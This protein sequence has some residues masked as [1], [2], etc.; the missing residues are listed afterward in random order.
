M[1][2]A[3]ALD[4]PDVLV[5]SWLV[6][7]FINAQR[8]LPG[9][10]RSEKKT[11]K[12]GA[13]ALAQLTHATK[14]AREH[15]LPLLLSL[16]LQCSADLLVSS[17]AGR[18]DVGEALANEASRVAGDQWRLEMAKQWLI[19][20]ALLLPKDTNTAL[21][22]QLH[23]KIADVSSILAALVDDDEASPRSSESESSE[24][25]QES[26][27]SLA[28]RALNLW[29]LL[30]DP[31]VEAKHLQPQKPPAWLL[32]PPLK[33]AIQQF[34]PNVCCIQVLSPFATSSPTGTAL[35][36]QP[37]VQRVRVHFTPDCDVQWLQHELT[38]LLRQCPPPFLTRSHEYRASSGSGEGVL[39]LESIVA[40]DALFD[41]ADGSKRGA[42]ALPLVTK[43]S[44]FVI[45]DGHVLTA[46][47]ALEEEIFIEKRTP[48]VL[49]VLCSQ[50]HTR[51]ALEDAEAHSETCC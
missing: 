49:T 27:T 39:T 1:S 26:R 46:E 28:T 19:E 42:T 4:E 48:D 50:C 41:S 30:L 51:V 11:K 23:R 14:L 29:S 45:A 2:M 6:S 36:Q 44:A 22:M 35:V 5:L 20:A 9:K 10:Q 7:G 32:S 24:P 8:A 17:T 15:C 21:K 12:V 25:V 33:S 40:V 16:S 13:L 37:G 34:K 43:L 18:V 3:Q 47:L 38:K 31:V